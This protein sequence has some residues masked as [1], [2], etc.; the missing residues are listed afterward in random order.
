MDRRFR[1]MLD[2]IVDRGGFRSASPIL[3]GAMI[4]AAVAAGTIG[5]AVATQSRSDIDLVEIPPLS[6]GGNSE[7]G[8]SEAT[9]TVRVHVVGAVVDPGVH[10]LLEGGIVLDAILAAGGPSTEAA[11]ES[12]NLAET[13]WD[14]QQIRV[15]LQEEMEAGGTVSSVPAGVTHPGAPVNINVADAALL[16]TLPGIGP[17]TAAKI[18]DDR[19]RNG[20]FG[21]IDEL[22]RVSG[23][24]EKKVEAIR[25][26]IVAR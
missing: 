14:G 6:V 10:T 24:G 16:E 17:A 13:I 15:P 19:T 1:R 12:I 2:D 22:R 20:R 9:P 3:I 23:I 7:D 8:S 21:S 18:V 26:L 5:W 25:D 11:I 4:L